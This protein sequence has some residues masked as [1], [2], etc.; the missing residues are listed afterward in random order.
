MTQSSYVRMILL[1]KLEED[2]IR[3]R[4]NIRGKKALLQ[5]TSYFEQLVLAAPTNARERVTMARPFVLHSI[6]AAAPATTATKKP[7]RKQ[8]YGVLMSHI[9]QS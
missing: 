6:I 4:E 8:I 7:N 5:Y 9:L 1:V 2:T 3:F